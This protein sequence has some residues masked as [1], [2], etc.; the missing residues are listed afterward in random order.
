M[1]NKGPAVR[2]RVL[3]RDKIGLV[4]PLWEALNE[5]HKK[6]SVHFK[7]FFERFTFEERLKKYSKKSV[8][9]RIDL[10]LIG[11]KPVGVCLSSYDVRK[12][13]RLDTIFV[14]P[15]FRNKGI[16]AALMKRAM[17]WF[18]AS[19]VKG[20]SIS[21]LYGNEEVFPFYAK[22]GFRPMRYTLLPEKRGT[23]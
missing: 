20:S 1:S 15:R 4:R 6:R 18:K 19:G 10:A 5:Y 22:F 17:R 9:V 8:K 3:P 14:E 16:G 12:E 13:G 21:V 7:K 11:D 23:R 2:Y